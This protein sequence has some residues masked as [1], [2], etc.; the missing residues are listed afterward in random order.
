[1]IFRRCKWSWGVHSKVGPYV[2]FVRSVSDIQNQAAGDP[3]SSVTLNDHFNLTKQKA[4]LVGEVGFEANYR[5]TPTMTG[6]VSYD[7]MWISGLAL[8]PEQ[9]QFVATP[10]PKLNTNGNIFAHG[11]TMGLEWN[12]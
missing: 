9:L 8:A 12:W 4:A 2:N 11:L 6:R 7:F 10:G 1:M 5:F 3:F